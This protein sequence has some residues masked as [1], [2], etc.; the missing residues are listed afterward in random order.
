MINTAVLKYSKRLRAVLLLFSF[1][2]AVGH[3]YLPAKRL[4]LHPDP[5]IQQHIYGF[6]D[7]TI[8][9]SSQW[10][11][12]SKGEWLCNFEPSQEFGCG[13]TLNLD[14]A[15][16]EGVDFSHYKSLSWT[17]DYQGP[18]TKLR[19]FIRNYEPQY[20]EHGNA[21]STKFLST[22]FAFSER[23]G[24]R[25]TIDLDNFGTAEWWLN[26]SHERRRWAAATRDNVVQ[27]GLD[28]IEP[29]R[30]QI[31]ISQVT[32]EGEWFSTPQVM[33]LLL[34]VWTAIFIGDGARLLWRKYWFNRGWSKQ[35]GHE[36]LLE[37]H[38]SVEKASLESFAHKDPLTGV[39]NRQGALSKL[40]SFSEPRSDKP[41]SAVLL[42]DLDQFKRV[43]E[44]LG[45][46][47]GDAVLRSFGAL[48]QMNTDHSDI[49]ARWGGKQFILVCDC[50]QQAQVLHRA[51]KLR[52]LTAAMN[53]NAVGDITLTLSVGIAVQAES[54]TFDATLLRAQKALQIA[55]RNGRNQVV[56]DAH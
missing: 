7:P 49:L 46:D 51:E 32:A 22:L 4:E 25:I 48:L 52:T 14:E 44:S 55:K 31:R 8:G 2:V 36:L 20:S 9:N 19:A 18:G 11:D 34:V 16:E 1:V 5:H 38:L 33:L 37:P 29:G 42:L 15:F 27:L 12:E 35:N 3:P 40:K 53:F 10:L 26:E 47:K 6:I 13:Y 45:H 39:L 28:F 41:K 24:N 30:H 56:C 54:E 17:L 43:N 23:N 21:S 50:E